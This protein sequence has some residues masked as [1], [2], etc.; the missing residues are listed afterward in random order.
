MNLQD[1]KDS[2][3]HE[4]DAPDR[5]FYVAA[6]SVNAVRRALFRAPGGARVVG[7]HDRETIACM[8]TMD[9][10]SYAR[11]WPVLLS[12]LDKAG[13]QVAPRPGTVDDRVR[14]GI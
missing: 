11:H 8:H 3:P 1:S 10:R 2:E 9:A 6:P 4:E 13:L 12:R 5:R 14:R 7:R